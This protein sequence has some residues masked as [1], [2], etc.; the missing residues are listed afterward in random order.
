MNRSR[1]RGRSPLTRPNTASPNITCKVRSCKVRTLLNDAGF[2]KTHRKRDINENKLYENCRECDELVKFGQSGLTCDKCEVWYHTACV[3]I[4]EEQYACM[5]KN[6][7]SDTGP[8]FHWFCR[9]CKD[10][11]TE[12]IDKIDLLETQT[13]NVASSITKLTE[14]VDNIEKKMSTSVVKNV[15][16]QLDERIDVDRRKMNLMVFNVENPNVARDDGTDSKWYTRK[17]KE[18]DIKVFIDIVK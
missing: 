8:K 2:C 10:V 3:R 14:R 9:F 11:V 1:G 17:K 13:R 18:S 5:V 6:K 15:K 16:S 4:S 7:E 12:A